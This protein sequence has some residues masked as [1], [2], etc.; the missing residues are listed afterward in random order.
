MK[1]CGYSFIEIKEELTGVYLLAGRTVSTDLG[2]DRIL[3][4]RFSPLMVIVSMSV[5]QIIYYRH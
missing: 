4:D 2:T 3:S 1:L 5:L